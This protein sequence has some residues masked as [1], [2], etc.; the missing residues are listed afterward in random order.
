MEKISGYF[1]TQ[2]KEAVIRFQEKYKEDILIPNDL[3][4]GT[5]KVAGSTI[6]KL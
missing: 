4:E 2:T 3:K 1:G 6:K 5:G